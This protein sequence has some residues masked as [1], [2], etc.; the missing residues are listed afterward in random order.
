MPQRRNEQECLVRQNPFAYA[1]E[2]DAS[3]R[4]EYEAW[5]E[6]G[7]SFTEA[8]WIACKHSY[9]ASGNL[10][11]TKWAQDTDGRVGYFSCVIG[12]NN[13]TSALS[14]LTYV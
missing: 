4:P 10:V 8:K 6:V 3:N 9:N 2:F 5:A 7:A 13:T 11:R 1:A 12:D 14:G